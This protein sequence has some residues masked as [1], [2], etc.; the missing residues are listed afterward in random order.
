[1]LRSSTMSLAL[2][3][4][5]FPSQEAAILLPLSSVPIVLFACEWSINDSRPVL[6]NRVCAC[7]TL[8]QPVANFRPG[9]LLKLFTGRET[10]WPLF[11][12]SILA[13]SGYRMPRWAVP[14]V[15][16]MLFWVKRLSPRRLPSASRGPS[17]GLKVA[18][19]ICRLRRTGADRWTT[20]RQLSRTM[21]D[22][23]VSRGVRLPTSAP[24]APDSRH[25]DLIG[26]H[27]FLVG[28]IGS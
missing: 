16:K 4:L 28:P 11:C 18:A 10:R 15:P 8:T 23:L 21:G 1:M 6:S 14:L 20:L 27:L 19:R 17:S 5:S 12:N 2:T 9:C 3:W 25:G 26:H 24:C 7:S 22:Y 13:V